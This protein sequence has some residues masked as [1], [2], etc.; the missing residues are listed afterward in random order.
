[1]PR[2]V[3][4][5]KPKAKVDVK[6]LVI[7]SAIAIPLA[8]V[9]GLQALSSVSTKR[10]P[11]IAA[12]LF[13][14]NGQALENV[15]FNLFSAEATDIEAIP[16]AARNASDKA[17]EAVRAEPLSPKAHAIL[18]MASSDSEERRQIIETAS[19]L[20]RRN[21][22]LQGLVFQEHFAQGNDEAALETLDQILRVHPRR[23]AE[24]FPVLTE[25][26]QADDGVANFE[27][28]LATSSPWHDRFLQHAVRQRDALPSLAELRR[29]LPI[30]VGDFDRRLISGLATSG[31]LSGAL[32]LLE[33]IRP[34]ASATSAAGGSL[35]LGWEDEYPPF[36]WQFT[37]EPGF[38]AQ[39][40]RDADELSLSVRPG[41]GGVIAARI[42]PVPANQFEV[43]IDYRISPANQA[44]DLRLQMICVDTSEQFYDE[45]FSNTDGRFVID[46]M[47]SGCEQMLLAINARA[48][49]GRSPLDAT[50]SEVTLKP[51]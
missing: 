5:K 23:S 3:R 35:T 32:S 46:G 20:N 41:K 28:L 19:K 24:F 43:Q 48:W 45:R 40:A 15:A 31:D 47:P 18:A 39:T 14:G 50:I 30:G 8:G 12:Q 13:P 2:K 44:R 9:L 21:L 22:A 36:D 37:N 16:M 38:R 4:Q 11:E 10:A 6:R 27:E 33:F 1:M 26:L 49:T 29:R 17:L 7:A 42:L 51:R 34:A 25:A